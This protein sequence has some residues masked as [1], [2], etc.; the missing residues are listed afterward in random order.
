MGYCLHSNLA[1]FPHIFLYIYIYIYIY[2]YEII[3][4]Y[5][6]KKKKKKKKKKLIIVCRHQ[7]RPLNVAADN[8]SKS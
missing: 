1:R 6:K 2:I 5:L 7:R 8:V 4:F 3:D